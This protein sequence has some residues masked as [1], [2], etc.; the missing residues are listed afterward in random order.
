L[1][2]TGLTTTRNLQVIGVATVG[3]IKIDTNTVSTTTGNLI[4]DSSAGTTQINDALYINDS[5]PSTTKD[6]GSIITEGGVG[7]EGNLNVGGIVKLATSGGITTTGGDLYVNGDLYTTKDLYLDEI[8]ARY[9]KFS[10]NLI[11]LG[12]PTTRFPTNC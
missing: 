7:I 11:V 6:T 9:G 1:G 12:Y 2:V 3:N 8:F 4:L 5:T 10:E